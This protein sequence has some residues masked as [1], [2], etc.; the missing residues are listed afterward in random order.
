MP[1][2]SRRRSAPRPVRRELRRGGPAARAAGMWTAVARW[3][4]RHSRPKPHVDHDLSGI[5]DVRFQ[6]PESDHRVRRG[7]DPGPRVAAGSF[8]H[9]MARCDP[10]DADARKG[11]SCSSEIACGRRSGSADSPTA[12]ATPGRSST[13]RRARIRAC[14]PCAGPRKR[15][16]RGDR[17]PTP[18]PLRVLRARRDRSVPAARGRLSRTLAVSRCDVC[19]VARKRVQ[20]GDE[21]GHKWVFVHEQRRVLRAL[22]PRVRG[23]RRANRESRSRT[24]CRNRGWARSRRCP[25]SSFESRLTERCCRW[26]RRSVTQGPARSVRPTEPR[27]IEPPVKA[28]TGRPSSS[29]TYVICVGGVTGSVSR[30]E[31]QRAELD[32]LAVGD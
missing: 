29:R 27:S 12:A 25:A 28:A 32:L 17:S 8:V 15:D 3:P 11:T 24:C 1:R 14:R 5:A 31:P 7:L 6:L 13:G 20:T 10:V 30:H 16:A 23:V 21:A 4:S 9:D 22:V 2:D 18:L 19:V 26:L